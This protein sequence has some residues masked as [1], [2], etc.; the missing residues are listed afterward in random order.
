[1]DLEHGCGWRKPNRRENFH[2]WDFLQSMVY[3]QISMFRTNLCHGLLP[4]GR[5]KIYLLFSKVPRLENGSLKET[6]PALRI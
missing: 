4:I 5:R 1:M 6:P 2:P 3:G